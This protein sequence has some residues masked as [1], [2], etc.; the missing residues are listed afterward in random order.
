MF[1]W[2][3]KQLKVNFDGIH[4]MQWD[5]FVMCKGTT[6]HELTKGYRKSAGLSQKQNIAW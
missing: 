3:L 2:N 5:E 4:V 6:Y 1:D